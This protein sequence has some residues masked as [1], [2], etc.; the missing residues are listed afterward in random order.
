MK[1]ARQGDTLQISSVLEL[2]EANAAAF[3]DWV[4]DLLEDGHRNIEVDLS[5]TT[6]VDSSGLGALV[7]LHKAA[8]RRSGT[9]RLVNPRPPVQQILELTRLDGILEIVHR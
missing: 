4:N 5:Q 6:F 9:L 2:G 1:V 3:R 7:S 8:G